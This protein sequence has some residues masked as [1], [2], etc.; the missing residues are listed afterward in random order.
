MFSTI[1]AALDAYFESQ[2]TGN[3]LA[4]AWEDVAF[5]PQTGTPYL[6]PTLSAYSRMPA[7]PGPN[8]TFLERG[9]YTVAV[10]WP[11]G[12]GK[13]AALAEADKVKTWFPRGLS[14]T[15]ANQAPLI[16]QYATLGPSVDSGDWIKVPVTVNWLTE[17]QE[18]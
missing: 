4:V 8:T 16:V 13:G 1:S 6:E 18:N 10:V 17:D 2:L 3:A 14:L 15:L 12:S 5:T 7:G 9:T 11:A